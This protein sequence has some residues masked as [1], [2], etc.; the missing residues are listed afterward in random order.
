MLA[1]DI[2]IGISIRR[3]L[4][5]G[6]ADQA[7]SGKH[8]YRCMRVLKESFDAL[9]QFF[10]ETTTNNYTDMESELLQ[11][12]TD[13]RL[14]P[15]PGAVDKVLDLES[16]ET[17]FLQLKTESSTQKG[18]TVAFLREISSLLALV[19]AVREGDFDRH[20]QAERDM[21]RFLFAFDHQ[22]YARYLSYQHVYLSDL[23]LTNNAAYQD[24]C[25][26]GFGANYSGDTF[27]NVHGDLV[28]EYFNKET[29]GTAG[30][31]RLGYSTN[32]DVFNKWVNNIHIHAKLRTYMREILRIKTTSTHKELTDS[33]RNKHCKNVMALK[34]KLKEYKL[35]P[36]SEDAA[37]VICTGMA[38]DTKVIADVLDSPKIGNEKYKA[39]VQSRLV[40]GKESIFLPIKKLKLNTG[41]KVQKKTCSAVS[42]LKEDRQAFGVLVGKAATLEEAFTFPITSIPLSLATPEGSL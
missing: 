16:F 30:P 11:R 3:R 7:F 34:Q 23:K 1:W 21:L 19:S 12:L 8:Y 4:H 10:A 13:L 15:T 42:V 36:F 2:K 26:R 32:L 20:L 22:N 37:K 29:K 9:V 38:V 24:L 6:P 5:L 27:A 35:D 18:M 28:T 17:F 25:I 14:E 39:F 41:L 33:G 40:E 31:F